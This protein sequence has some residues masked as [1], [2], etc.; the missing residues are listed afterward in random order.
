[1]GISK[2]FKKKPP[3]TMELH[4]DDVKYIMHMLSSSLRNPNTCLS[5]GQLKAV[6]EAAIAQNYMLKKRVAQLEA[7]LK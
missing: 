7:Y 1:M 5:K 4:P 3:E 2:L 6:A